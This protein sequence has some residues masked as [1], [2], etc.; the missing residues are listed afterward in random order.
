[1]RNE[2]IKLLIARTVKK[3]QK[4][5]LRALLNHHCPKD[6]RTAT[7]SVYKFLHSVAF[8][9]GWFSLLG[10]QRKPIENV[11]KRFISRTMS[12]RILLGDLMNRFSVK[13]MNILNG[14]RVVVKMN[15][16]SKILV[17][18]VAHFLQTILKSFFH[19]TDST[20]RKYQVFYFRKSVWQAITHK[21]WK[22]Q[23]KSG[24]LM[25]LKESEFK[26]LIQSTP[27]SP[28]SVNFRMIPKKS[29]TEV[30]LISNNVS[31]KNLDPMKMTLVKEFSETFGFKTDLSGYR[32]YLE[33]SRLV[34]SLDNGRKLFW[35]TAD[36]SDAFGSIKLLTLVAI[37][38]KLQRK[39]PSNSIKHK[40]TEDLC[41]RLFLQTGVYNVGKRTKTFLLKRGLLQGDPLSPFL[42]DIYYGDMISQEMKVFLKV[43]YGEVELFLR[44][45]DDFI[46]L[47]TNR[48]RVRKFRE[49]IFK[50]F[51][52]YNCYFKSSKTKTNLEEENNVVKYCGAVIDL[53]TREIS[54]NFSTYENMNIYN[55]QS[56]NQKSQKA[57]QFILK[58][59]LLFCSVRQTRLYLGGYNSKNT[60]LTTICCNISIALRRLTCMIDTLIWSR[61]Q[62]V[63]DDWL[64]KVL[65]CG[66][67]RFRWTCTK[68][69]LSLSSVDYVAFMCLKQE[70]RRSSEYSRKIRQSVE[71]NLNMFQYKIDKTHKL[72]EIVA[73]AH[74]KINWKSIH[75]KC[76]FKL[77]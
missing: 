63:D 37:L 28:S 10:D 17:W 20:H 8:Q 61:R 3:F 11:I 21:V 60:L 59:F 71:N 4:L 29:M 30:R 76:G 67:R 49:V 24:K 26:S 2:E 55:L 43:P 14:K 68:S 23:S 46:F 5:N 73:I 69:G 33:W 6:G 64:W 47:S 1:M 74:D 32:L 75:A 36:I 13:K 44:G 77:L 52:N 72:Q 25:Q 48:G 7:P 18:F 53:K 65:I 38:K 12:T 42:N 56:W 45:T 62:K 51:K 70:L 41:K 31:K 9:S 58:R 19:L 34:Q 16:F 54:P 22:D 66:L 57:G 50:G 15:I 40:D 35:I 27:L 39:L